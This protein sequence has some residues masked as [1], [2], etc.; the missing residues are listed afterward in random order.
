MAARCCW[1]RPVGGFQCQRDNSFEMSADRSWPEHTCPS[2]RLPNA[3][4]RKGAGGETCLPR[5][6]K[7]HFA[8]GLGG[9]PVSPA[10]LLLALGLHPALH[11]AG[12]GHRLL[13]VD[14][15]DRVPAGGVA[16]PT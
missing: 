16:L 2:Q 7:R 8:E 9:K 3:T 12:F 6:S 1:W 11:V 14:V 5:I 10:S 13:R 15:G 4:L